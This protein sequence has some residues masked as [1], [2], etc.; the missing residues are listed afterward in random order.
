MS[1]ETL[2]DIINSQ[3]GNTL[4]AIRRAFPEGSVLGGT[5]NWRVVAQ[6]ASTQAFNSHLADECQSVCDWTELGVEIY[7]RLR[8]AASEDEDEMAE[9]RLRANAILFCGADATSSI[10]NPTVI[11]RWFFGSI[12]FS[13][14]EARRR[15]PHVDDVGSG[16]FAPLRALKERLSI[17]ESLVKAHVIEKHDQL[18]EWLELHQHLP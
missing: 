5:I 8:T 15:I 14:E 12:P 11:E 6:Y 4:N 16:D 7:R 17:I 1:I 2:A 10:R 9:M 13:V 3:P 18:S